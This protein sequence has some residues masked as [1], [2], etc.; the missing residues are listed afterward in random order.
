MQKYDF[1]V[2]EPYKT[3]ILENIKTVEGRLNKGKFKKMNIWDILSFE[4]GE[5]FT[6]TDKRQYKTFHEMIK[7]EWIK[8]VIPDARNIDEAVDAYYQFYTKQQEKEFWVVAISIQ[9]N[10]S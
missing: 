5:V 3:Y 9:K 8:V 4:T 6:I 10:L 7:N 1:S 2:Q